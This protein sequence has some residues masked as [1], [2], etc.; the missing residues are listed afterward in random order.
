MG[1]G[2]GLRNAV[3]S[4]GPIARG[5]PFPVGPKPSLDQRGCWY[6][7]HI[8]IVSAG[9]EI[10]I[11]NSDGIL[12]NIHTFPKD[13]QGFNMAQP[14]FRKVM[15]HAFER[16]DIIRVGC[17]VHGWMSAWIIVVP[18]PYYAVTG[19]D[20]SFDLANVPPGTYML[21]AW[22]ETL[23]A[24]EQTIRVTPGGTVETTLTYGG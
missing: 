13:G 7:P 5:K 16:P 2:G 3:V 11:L 9:G 19:D 6:I 4:L 24:R 10:D 14:K 23:G 22:H 15:T 12:H 17:D 20:G 18:H 21:D 8:L 1:S